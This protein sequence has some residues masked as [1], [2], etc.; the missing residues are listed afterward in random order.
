LLVKAKRVAPLIT[1]GN[2]ILAMLVA[3]RRTSARRG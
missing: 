2:E 1:E 3:S